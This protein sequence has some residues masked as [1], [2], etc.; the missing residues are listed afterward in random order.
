MA[1][2]KS[3]SNKSIVIG[4]GFLVIGIIAS[5]RYITNN[6]S[7]S[8]SSQVLGTNVSSVST[9]LTSKNSRDEFF[10]SSSVVNA[11][12]EVLVGKPGNYILL[13]RYWVD[14]VGIWREIPIDNSTGRP[15]WDKSSPWHGRV[16]SDYLPGSG[17][18]QAFDEINE[19]G[20]AILQ[21]LWRNNLGYTRLVP[22]DS[23]TGMPKW[24]EA[25]MWGKTKTVPEMAPGTGDAQALS[26]IY[27]PQYGSIMQSIVR[28]NRSYWRWEKLNPAN[29]NDW[30][31]GSEAWHGPTAANGIPGSGDIQS[32]SEYL[33][34]APANLMHQ[35]FWRG[36]KRYER[37][38]QLNS[39]GAPDWSKQTPWA[40]L[41]SWQPI[42]GLN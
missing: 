13:Q 40:V 42:K 10:S 33:L 36:G 27:Y 35:T 31:T 34:P 6:S 20:V 14:Q 22:I 24:D 5:Y 12:S 8:S 32:M 19:Y 7:A 9:P 39:S 21:S 3:S 23:S 30:A 1:K 29:I 18:I 25:G 4:L 16:F 17:P 37:E 11:E 41:D 38:V 15:N 28:G 26:G 2:N